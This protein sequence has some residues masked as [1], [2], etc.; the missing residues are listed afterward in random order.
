VAS[1]PTFA[2]PVHYERPALKLETYTA[3]QSVEP[4]TRAQF[5][6]VQRPT[7]CAGQIQILPVFVIGDSPKPFFD[8][9]R[10]P[11]VASQ[12]VKVATGQD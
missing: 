6:R 2:A 9:T 8:G 3:K 5:K 1:S 7:N 4:A 11:S 10:P 12:P